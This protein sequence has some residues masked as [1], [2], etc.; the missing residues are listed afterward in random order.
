M[1]KLLLFLLVGIVTTFSLTGCKKNLPIGSEDGVETPQTVK[2]G[3]IAPL[4]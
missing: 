2:I 4:S 3:V 1:K